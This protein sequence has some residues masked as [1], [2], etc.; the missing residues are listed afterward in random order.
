MELAETA[1]VSLAIVAAAVVDF[2]RIT[3]VEVEVATLIR[4]IEVAST[5]ITIE[6][7]TVDLHRM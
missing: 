4:A 6:K 5:T 3:E 1:V 2:I 7:V